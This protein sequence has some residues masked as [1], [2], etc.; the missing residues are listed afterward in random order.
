MGPFARK[1]TTWTVE[2]ITERCCVDAARKADMKLVDPDGH[3]GIEEFLMKYCSISTYQ[4]ACFVRT[5]VGWA[6][7][8]CSGI[9]ISMMTPSKVLNIGLDAVAWSCKCDVAVMVC[10]LLA[11]QIAQ[12][13]NAQGV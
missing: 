8:N 4:G 10:P 2:F 11:C 1:L 6:C 3:L 7:S 9:G 5:T 12:Q 13:N